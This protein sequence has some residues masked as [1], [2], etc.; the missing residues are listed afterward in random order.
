MAF[1]NPYQQYRESNILTASK[2]GLLLMTYDG[3]TRFITQAK[4]H[5][6]TKAYEQQNTCIIKAQR[7][8]LELIYTLNPNADRDLAQRL[9]QLYEYMFNRLVEANV[10]DDQA[11]LDEV[12]WHLSELRSAWAEADREVCGGQPAAPRI[13]SPGGERYAV[14][15]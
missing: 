1:N 9:T 11:A 2:G 7:L 12:L 10:N 8:L 15:A 3:A 14:A 5:M 13:H 4:A 6:S